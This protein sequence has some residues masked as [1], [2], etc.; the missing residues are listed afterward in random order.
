MKIPETRRI[1]SE[2]YFLLP[3]SIPVRIFG[4]F[5]RLIRKIHRGLMTV[6][7][8]PF[9]DQWEYPDSF[10]TPHNKSFSMATDFIQAYEAS[11]K[12]SGD[13]YRIPWR[14][15]QALW[16]A[17]S[18]SHLDGDIVELGTG[19]GF[20]MAAVAQA[21]SSRVHRD[22]RSVW[23][24]DLFEL[25]AESDEYKKRL[26]RYYAEGNTTVV[27]YFS[28][29]PYVKIVS[30]DIRNTLPHSCPA[31]ISFL[32]V[33]L[34]DAS[35]EIWA[36]EHLWEKLVPGSLIL[37]DDYANLGL[38]AQYAAVNQFISEKEKSILT[39][40]SGQGLILI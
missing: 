25:P 39:T 17:E 8:I 10:Y 4:V 40:P 32:H 38:E 19:K 28:K 12:A 20:I 37:F 34:N 36:L 35:A 21:M 23:L 15:H 31:S 29:W 14:V 1:G 33:D 9:V 24:Y 16:C 11:V 2:D 3:S 26:G 7:G 6:K 22:L 18:T 5:H 30:G 27:D 13:D